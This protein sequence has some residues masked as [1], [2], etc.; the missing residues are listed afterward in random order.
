MVTVSFWKDTFERAIS[1]A[2]E[3]AAALIGTNQ[4]GVTQLD[5]KSIASVSATAAI[6]TILKAIGASK[7]SGTQSASLVAPKE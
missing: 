5:W 6:L 3:T 4:V 2:A 7:M 1:T